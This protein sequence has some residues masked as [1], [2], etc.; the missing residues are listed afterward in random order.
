MRRLLIGMLL[1]AAVPLFAAEKA[2]RTYMGRT[3]ADVMGPE[4][5]AWLERE[6]REAEERISKLIAA[7]PLKPG[8]Q[9]A[10]VGAGSGVL[11]RLMAPRLLPGGMVYAV[12]IQQDMLDRINQENKAKGI[13][14]IRTILGGMKSPKLPPGSIDLVLMVDVYHEF[15][16]PFEMLKS[17]SESL[18][19]GGM[20]ALVEYRGEDPEVPI[21][22]EHKMT[23]EQIRKEFARP[24]LR[25]SWTRVES[26][27]PRQHLVFFS[28]R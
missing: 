21:R 26:S 15:D 6:N 12:D 9:V 24:E 13:T 22:A 28:R 18:K 17:I 14:N 16:H 27:L 23:L 20:I 7:L 1:I 5:I 19:K 4:G 25:L 11:S 10:D 3:L 8:L 2:K